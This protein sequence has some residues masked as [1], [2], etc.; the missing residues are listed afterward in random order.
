MQD[1]IVWAKRESN[2]ESSNSYFVSHICKDHQS[3]GIWKEDQETFNSI[4]Q[5]LAQE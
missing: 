4:S 5:P 2:V 1:V 3:K